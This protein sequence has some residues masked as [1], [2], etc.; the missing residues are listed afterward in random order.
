MALDMLFIFDHDRKVVSLLSNLIIDCSSDYS[1][2]FSK[3][4]ANHS[5]FCY[6]DQRI[7]NFIETDAKVR[8]ESE[9]CST[10][11]LQFDGG[12]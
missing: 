9:N 6:S 2:P 10:W 12:E 5:I 11:G 1:A 4:L 7:W 8:A 3:P